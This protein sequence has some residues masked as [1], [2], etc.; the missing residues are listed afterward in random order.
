MKKVDR[1]IRR[2]RRL[3]SKALTE[4]ILEKGFDDVTIRDITERADVAYA[5]FF[6]HYDGKTDLLIEQLESI[7][8]EMETQAEDDGNDYFQTEGMLLFTYTEDNE[9]FFRSLLNSKSNRFVMQRFKEM[10]IANLIDR[11]SEW[12]SRL[13]NPNFP[14]ELL[15]NHTASSALELVAWWLENDK[16][17]SVA[18][19]GAIY[20]RLIIQSTWHAVSA[21]FEMNLRWKDENQFEK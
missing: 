9:A 3:L 7:M 14:L 5:T 20:E 1:R 19:M 6:R 8:S 18:R 15:L 13:K 12:Y 2:T 4:L 11:A 10:I 17:L 16:P 21:E